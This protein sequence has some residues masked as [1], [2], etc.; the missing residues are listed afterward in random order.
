MDLLDSFQTFKSN[1]KLQDYL[2]ERE[3]ADVLEDFMDACSDIP[4]TDILGKLSSLTPRYY[5]VSSSCVVVS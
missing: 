4:L 5:S 1:V 2:N 3:V